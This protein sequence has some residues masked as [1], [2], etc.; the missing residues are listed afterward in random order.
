[1]IERRGAFDGTADSNCN[2]LD[3]FCSKWTFVIEKYGVCDVCYT[4]YHLH[5]LFHLCLL[6]FFVIW[7]CAFAFAGDGLW[8]LLGYLGFAC[9]VFLLYCLSESFITLRLIRKY[10]RERGKPNEIFTHSA[11]NISK[12]E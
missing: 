4:S 12:K 10:Q 1:M 3:S 7:S 9:C 2:L 5:F 8:Y 6:L 11:E